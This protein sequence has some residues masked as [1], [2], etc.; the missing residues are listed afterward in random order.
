MR[1]CLRLAVL[2]AGGLCIAVWTL[3]AAERQLNG[4][5]SVTLTDTT[6]KEL[7]V[8]SA[9]FHNLQSISGNNLTSEYEYCSVSMNSLITASLGLR[10]LSTLLSFSLLRT[11][12]PLPRAALLP[13]P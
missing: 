13:S 7:E 11:P 6:S 10:F 3:F 8:T 12:R 1:N 2:Q 5:C 9:Q 4:N